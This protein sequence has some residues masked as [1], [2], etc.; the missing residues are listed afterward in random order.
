VSGRV[1]QFDLVRRRL[2]V[3]VVGAS[4]ASESRGPCMN[5]VQDNQAW[6][7]IANATGDDTTTFAS[8]ENSAIGE[9][10][11]WLHLHYADYPVDDRY[12]ITSVKLHFLVRTIQ[13]AIIGH[14]ASGELAWYDGVTTRSLLAWNDGRYNSAGPSSPPYEATFDITPHV[15]GWQT[16]NSLRADALT[17]FG[18]KV[19][20]I[21]RIEL[22]RVRLD[23]ATQA[24]DRDANP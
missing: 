22:Y 20:D 7:N 12:R 13:W 17:S 15:T 3:P 19:S 11:G 18:I 21:Q 8:M 10:C 1:R 5:T 4:T 24:R 16:L 14:E 9:R 2:N 6:Q 23:V